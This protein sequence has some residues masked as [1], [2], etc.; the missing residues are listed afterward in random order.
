MTYFY[1]KEKSL[2]KFSFMIKKIVIFAAGCAVLF[3]KND[4]DVA[5]SRLISIVIT[6][7]Q[8]I[9]LEH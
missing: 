9:V 2:D 3:A 5:C 1:F 6:V 7:K 8:L 4:A